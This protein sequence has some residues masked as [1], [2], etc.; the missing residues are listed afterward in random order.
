MTVTVD[1]LRAANQEIDRLLAAELHDFFGSLNLSDPE[2]AKAMVLDTTPH[3]VQEWGDT[4][5]VAA[6]EWYDENRAARQIAGR[7]RAEMAAPVPNKV[8]EERLR[9]GIGH[10]FSDAPDQF[11]PWLLDAMQEYAQ[12]PGRDTISRSS[13]RDPQAFGWRRVTSFGACEYC[14]NLASNGAVWTRT[15]SDFKAHGNCNCVAL[16]EWRVNT[17]LPVDKET[18][19]ALP[20][21]PVHKL[22]DAELQSALRRMRQ[23][24]D[25]LRDLGRAESM[26]MEVI[27]QLIDDMIREVS[28]RV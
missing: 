25:R 20:K 19:A 22:T 11:L 14:T 24:R 13:I 23:Q 8:I 3:L 5:A 12:Q 28:L 10:L 26:N 1:E 27:L 7:F 6:Q 15:S 17:K 16:P 2:A 9:Y 18:E 4:S 21:K